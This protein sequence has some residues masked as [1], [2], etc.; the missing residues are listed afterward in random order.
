MTASDRFFGFRNPSKG[1]AA[2]D[3]A[4]R[5][6][7]RYSIYRHRG[8]LSK[9]TGSSFH[10]VFCFLLGGKSSEKLYAKHQVHINTEYSN[11]TSEYV[12]STSLYMHSILKK[13]KQELC[14]LPPTLFVKKNATSS[15]MNSLVKFIRLLLLLPL[16]L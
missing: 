10:G 7:P 12:R 15:P 1:M 5:V 9:R 4:L 13:F 3:D 14:P 6:C 2:C 16:L 8:V 11:Q